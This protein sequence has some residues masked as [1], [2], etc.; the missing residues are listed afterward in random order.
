MSNVSTDVKAGPA[1]AL[2]SRG[3]VDLTATIGYYAMIGCALNAFVVEP[4]PGEPPLPV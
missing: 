3:L 4:T 2:R 1:E